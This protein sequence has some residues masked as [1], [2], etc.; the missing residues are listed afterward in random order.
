MRNRLL[1]FITLFFI[2]M[3]VSAQVTGLSGW[4]VFLDPGHSGTENMGIYNYSEAHKVLR[5]ALNLRDM[6]LNET[7]IDT[8]YLSRTNDQQS[9]SLSQRTDHANTVGAAW[10]HSIHSDASSTPTTNSTLMLWGQYYNGLEKVPNGGK[11]MSAIMVDIL[12]RGYRTNTRGSWGDC[13]FYG[14]CSA[15]F[16]GPYLHVNRTTTMP[17]ELSE[18]GFHTNPTQNMINM[19]A[20]WKKLEARTFYWSFLKHKNIARPYVGIAAGHVKDADAGHFLNGAVVT[21]NGDTI[22]T[23]THQSLFHL[24]D[25][26]NNYNLR[27][28]FF[29]FENVPAGTHTITVSAE[30]YD[31]Y[32][33][34]VTMSDTFFTF[35][36]PLMISSI[37]PVIASVSPEPNDSIYPG[38]EH[39]IIQFSRPM[40]KASVENNLVFSPSASPTYSWSDGDR[41]LTIIS[42]TLALGTNYSLTISGNSFDKFNHPFDGNGDG[43]GGDDYTLNFV[44]E[45]LDVSAPYVAQALPDVSGSV[46]LQPVVNIAFNELIS[47]STLTNRYKLFKTSDQSVVNAAPKY[48]SVNRKGV[49][50]YF[51]REQLEPST[52]YTFRLEPGIKDQKGN[53]MT[54]TFEH[55]FITGPDPGVQRNVIDTFEGNLIYWPNPAQN[56]STTGIIP[57]LTFNSSASSIYNW[58]S[59][60]STKS[61]KL[62]I[63]WDPNATEW[64][65]RQSYIGPG[66]ILTSNFK[67]TT[68][69]FGDGLNHKFRFS[70]KDGGPG[71]YEVSPWMNID[72]YGWK[73]V[74]W[75]PHM[76]GFGSWVG[77]NTFQGTVTFDS[78]QFTYTPGSKQRA[79]YYIDDASF[80]ASPVVDV[81]EEPVKPKKYALEQN[82][83]NPFNPETK[84]NFSLVKT[85]NV[86]L[87]VYNLIGQKVATLVN[88]TMNSGSHTVTFDAANMPSGVYIYKLTTP[89]YTSSKKLVIMK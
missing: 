83:P 37:P 59:V 24:Y 86:K 82:Y 41:K 43:V 84:I 11:A 87:E 15:S 27:N 63:G 42:N 73:E 45:P 72:W 30:G 3:P 21:F 58:T 88:G 25:P 49:F 16:T 69:I 61:M 31:P 66:K 75:T 71:Q 2:A 23:D 46:S 7:D 68:F 76:D 10:Y 56:T 8:V 65:V 18:A 80:M 50:S 47:A 1:L 55:T 89:E 35:I 79:E 29:Y 85:G 9:V 19:N 39:I 38:I 22:T 17:S 32:T 6:L 20:L 57:F 28:G 54:E 12:T 26:S 36:D 33:K 4:N 67:L 64:L 52:S 74:T 78:Y 5:V 13:S 60:S 40:D 34:Q 53:E 62:D 81:K 14:T 48:Y 51:V 77:D 70:V 44:T